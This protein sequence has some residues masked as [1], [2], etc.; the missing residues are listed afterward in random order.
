M[1]LDTYI[2]E[3]NLPYEFCPGCSHGKVLGAVS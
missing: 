2:A 1:G 3:E